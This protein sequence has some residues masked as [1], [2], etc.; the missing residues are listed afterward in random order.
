M[1][2]KYIVPVWKN[3]VAPC[4]GETGCPAYTDIAGSLHAM[5]TRDM[6]K[7]WEIMMETHPLRGVLGRICYGFCETPCNRGF[8]DTSISIQMLEAVIGDN[9]FDPDWRPE[10][11]PRNGKKVAVIGAGPAGLAA[12]WFLNIAGYEAVIYEA[13]K[14]AGGILQYGIPTYRLPREVLD[15]EIK[16]IEDCG[17]KIV[18][19]TKLDAADESFLEKEKIDAVIVAIG[20]GQS[21]SSGMEGEDKTLIGLEFLKTINTEKTHKRIF[22]G[23]NIIIIGGGN[24]SMDA[25]RSSVRIGAKSVKTLYRRTESEMPAH[26]HE[27]DEAKEEGV[28]FIFLMAPEKYENNI[29]TARK[30]ELGEP[31]ESGRRKPVPSDETEK[32]EADEVI[33]AIGQEAS[34]FKTGELKNIFFA[35]DVNPDSEGTVIHAIASGK[36]AAA[37]VHKLLE[38]AT[39]FT[40][41]AEEV[42]YE[43]MNI[44]RYFEP[45]MRLRAPLAPTVARRKNFEMT[46]PVVSLDEGVAEA[47]RC[48]RCGMC[49]GGIN[50]DCDW[51]FRACGSKEGIEKHMVEWNRNGPL[52]ETSNNCDFCGKCWEDCPRYVVTPVEVEENE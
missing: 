52:F 44:A 32:F 20:S 18:Y 5:S 28:E 47:M 49:I 42:P 22:E 7:A 37:D 46:D 9:G 8:F 40:P 35:G 27:V 4:G 3:K 21:R 12:G 1:A 38:G 14:K 29:L 50:S 26:Q 31:D 17:V 48:F 13:E 24:V 41:L 45:R 30:M 15:R 33:M 16:L 2:P 19:N 39:L 34:H 43:K 11:A 25:C 23:K 6:G 10:M 51:C 36:R